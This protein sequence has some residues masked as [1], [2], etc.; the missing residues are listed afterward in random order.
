MDVKITTRKLNESIRDI[1]GLSHSEVIEWLKLNQ[2][3]N[4]RNLIIYLIRDEFIIK[5]EGKYYLNKNKEPIHYS[6]VERW[7]QNLRR[8]RNLYMKTWLENK[9]QP[10]PVPVESSNLT[11]ETAIQFLKELGYLVYKKV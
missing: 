4:S 8:H 2:V 7:I 1:N 6:R 9:K 10:K 3:R 11:E 5:I